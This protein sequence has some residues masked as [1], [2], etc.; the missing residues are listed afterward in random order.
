MK[1]ST[2]CC[3]SRKEVL[4]YIEKEWGIP[5]VTRGKVID[6]SNL[7][8]F[9]AVAENTAAGAIVYQIHNNEC[10][11]V[12]LYSLTE[13]KGVGTELINAVIEAARE[14]NCSR[15]WL[16]TTND[17]TPAMRFYQKRGFTMKAVHVNAF[18][19]TQQIKGMGSG[20]ILGI[21][22]IPILHEVEFEMVLQP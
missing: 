19:I 7:P 10:E 20:V 6:L 21:D 18:K 8:G 12:V 3:N 9:V 15:V 11:I 5:I 1:I 4:A 13:N 14:Q 22:D 16:V 17:N 2:L